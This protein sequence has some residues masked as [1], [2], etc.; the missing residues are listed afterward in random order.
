MA[1]K[2][3]CQHGR[4]TPARS[5]AM[6]DQ[7]SV[8]RQYSYDKDGTESLTY[9]VNSSSVN[10]TTG[11]STDSSHFGD[12][13]KRVIN[14]NDVSDIPDKE[15]AFIKSV[16]DNDSSNKYMLAGQHTDSR[17]Y[18]GGS[19]VLFAPAQHSDAK[20]SRSRKAKRDHRLK[21]TEGMS[22]SPSPPS[23]SVSTPTRKNGSVQHPSCP[24]PTPPKQS[25]SDNVWYTQWWMCG[26]ADSLI[27]LSSD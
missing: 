23:S 20:S 27:G 17:V 25:D 18:D 21:Q 6:V 3:Q 24:A 1:V 9:S 11:E 26:F 22:T 13:L 14:D 4:G 12:F 7:S 5:Y 2:K 16:S 10:S 8:R 15:M 19:Q